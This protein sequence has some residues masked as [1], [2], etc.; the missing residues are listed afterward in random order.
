MSCPSITEVSGQ[1]ILTKPQ[2]QNQGFYWNKNI[3]YERATISHQSWA[4][5]D[6]KW[7]YPG[8]T[9]NRWKNWRH[10]LYHPSSICNRAQRET[11][12]TGIICTVMLDNKSGQV[13]TKCKSIRCEL[14]C[15]QDFRHSRGEEALYRLEPRGGIL[16]MQS[17]LDMASSVVLSIIKVRGQAKD[18]FK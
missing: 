16:N 13:L 2:Q 1:Q 14:R 10:T 5:L 6:N 9:P 15:S 11:R 8:K 4:H 12:S 18:R 3:S 17:R 7:N